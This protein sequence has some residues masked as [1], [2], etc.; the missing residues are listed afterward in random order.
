MYSPFEFNDVLGP[1][2]IMKLV[3]AALLVYF[4]YQLLTRYWRRQEENWRK[5]AAD[6]KKAAE[7]VDSPS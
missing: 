5:I 3:L 6:S 4:L 7:R 1:L 2:I